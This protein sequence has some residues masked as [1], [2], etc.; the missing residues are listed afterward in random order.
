MKICFLMRKRVRALKP[1][2]ID[3][4]ENGALSLACQRA[5]PYVAAARARGTRD[6]YRRAFERWAAWCGAMRTE[7]LPAAPE[8]I[9]AYL[10]ELAV[11]GKSVASIKGALA[12]I[13]YTHRAQGHGIETQAPAIVAVM[14]GIT[15]RASRPIKRA[16]A[17]ELEALRTIIAGVEGA[18]IRAL[19]DRAL[20]LVGFFGALRRSELV[21]LEVKG[22][23]YVEIRAEGLVL[24]L[25]GTKAS[26]TTQTLCIPRRTDSLCAARAL[27]QY[28]AA[29]GITHGPLFRAVSKSGKL[30]ETRLDPT[31]VRHILKA[32]AGGRYSPHSLRAGF[33]TS[34][35]KRGVPEHVIQRTSR[36]KSADVLRTYIREGDNFAAC[37]A[38]QL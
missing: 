34:A 7:P 21:A 31:S 15:R 6:V 13:L 23:S 24:H 28:L 20:L 11:E 33:I 5:Q 12:S 30:L 18:G 9:A 35:A 26:A 27:D 25:T 1:Y 38:C 37:A 8:A 29:A 14:A 22:R 3:S 32:R 17:L 4:S 10:A 2:Q 19:R 36:H 16:P